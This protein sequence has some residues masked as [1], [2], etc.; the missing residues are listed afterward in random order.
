M[1]P[2]LF[3]RS[4]SGHENERLSSENGQ[5]EEGEKDEAHVLQTVRPRLFLM[6]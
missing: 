4:E 6:D 3:T 1:N 5:G 2:G